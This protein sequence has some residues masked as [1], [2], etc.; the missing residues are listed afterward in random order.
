MALGRLPAESLETLI[1]RHLTREEDAVTSALIARFRA[2]R[3]RGYLTKGE[4]IAA[5]RWKS[6]R[7]IGHV[8]GNDPRRVRK[9]T[10]SAL[11][12][13]SERERMEALLVLQGVSVPSGSAILTM[14]DPEHYGVIDIRAWQLL[15]RL[16]LVDGAQS[17]TGL[18]AAN[19]EAFLTAIR[20]LAAKLEATPRDIERALFYVHRDHQKDTLY[21][22][23]AG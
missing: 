8:V 17:G 1:Q 20:A 13:T 6:P 9:A 18:S 21:R 15:H 16:K 23:P 22:R 12:S 7:S 2:A 4:L 3:A 14:L 10:A 19:W 5:C 11:A